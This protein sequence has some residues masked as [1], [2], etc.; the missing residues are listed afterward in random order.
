MAEGNQSKSYRIDRTLEGLATKEQQIDAL[1]SADKPVNDRLDVVMVG[2][3]RKYYHLGLILQGKTPF[4]YN[5][6]VILVKNRLNEKLSDIERETVQFL[7]IDVPTIPY[8]PL[9][10]RKETL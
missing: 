7:D 3:P 1:L 4:P 10:S 6:D 5:I 9:D 2:Q 8:A